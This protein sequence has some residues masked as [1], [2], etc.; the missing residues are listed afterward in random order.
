MQEAIIAAINSAKLGGIQQYNN[1]AVAQ[2]LRENGGAGLERLVL[3]EALQKGLTITEKPDPSVPELE[4]INDTGKEVIIV[5][6]EY[7]LGGKQNRMVAAS[8]CLAPGYK[9]KIPVRCVQKGRWDRHQERKFSYGGHTTTDLKTPQ[10]QSRTWDG[11]TT[12]LDQTGI[13][14]HTEDYSQI[15]EQNAKDFS[16]VAG[17]FT[18][19]P[20]QV[21]LVA[22]IGLPEYRKFSIELFDDPEI[23]RKH[24]EKIMSAYAAEALPHIQTELS[25]TPREITEFLE[26]LKSADLKRRHSASRGED[27][28]ILT[29]GVEGST[30]ICDGKTTYLN[31]VCS[32][33]KP[34]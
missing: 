11:V 33:P 13:L 15:M 22:V 20:S 6:G 29:H 25:V 30:L 32:E 8:L 21:G 12:I 27:S 18:R 34:L 2:L 9:G 14:S 31:A 28:E 4:I 24:Y 7:I 16:D 26:G 17:K 3:E 19:H 5:A 10:D 1:L 23:M